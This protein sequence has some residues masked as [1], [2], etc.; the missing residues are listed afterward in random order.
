MRSIWIRLRELVRARA[1]DRESAE[2]L[3]HHVDLQVARYVESGMTEA[4]A[5][6]RVRLE[7]GSVEGARAQLADARS[8]FAM[9]QILREVIYALRVLR[10]SPGITLLSAVT[11]GAGIGL[12]TVLFALLDG[13]V[14]R[15][16]PYPDSDR[17]LSISEADDGRDGSVV[18]SPVLTAWRDEAGAHGGDLGRSRNAR[19]RG[20]CPFHPRDRRDG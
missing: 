4:D 19:R 20:L 16:L 1:L 3:A 15:P 17:I 12:G 11:M 9:E 8:G 2:E 6:R 10:R 14:L 7:L 5:R 18:A 13:I